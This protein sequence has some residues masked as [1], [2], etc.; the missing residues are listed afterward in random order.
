L[1]RFKKA[2]QI[3]AVLTKM[4]VIGATLVKKAQKVVFFVVPLLK[5]KKRQNERK[6]IEPA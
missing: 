2:T 3:K 5:K 4:T 1:S 6:L